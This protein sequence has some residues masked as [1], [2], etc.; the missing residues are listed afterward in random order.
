MGKAIISSHL[1][2][3]RYWIDVQYDRARA[4]RAIAQM[5]ANVTELEAKST[6]IRAEISAHEIEY[7]NLLAIVSPP[8]TYAQ[9]Y[10]LRMEIR[11]ME[12]QWSLCQLHVEA[13]NLKILNLQTLAA[14]VRREAWC[15]DLTKTLTGEVG[16]MEPNGLPGVPIIQPG[17]DANAVYDVVRDGFIQQVQASTPEATFWNLAML[18]GWQKWQ[19]TYRIGEITAI[20]KPGNKATVVLD[21]ALS[22]QHPWAKDINI[23][24]EETLPDIPVRYMT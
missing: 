11:G 7:L 18:P 3:G 6:R 20:D 16:T 10:T 8:A 23:N 1:G 22:N 24:V 13:Y 2:S 4:L 12:R 21:P 15:A 14:G 17:Y 19:P 9:L 5:Q